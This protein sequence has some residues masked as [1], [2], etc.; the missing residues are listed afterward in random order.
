M[1]GY[2]SNKPTKTERIVVR[3]TGSLVGFR[4]RCE[5]VADDGYPH[6]TFM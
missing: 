4:R 2:N 6:I 3:Y 1:T 5:Q